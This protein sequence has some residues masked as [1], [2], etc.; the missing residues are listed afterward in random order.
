M[1]RLFNVYY[2][3]RTLVLL[4]VET[5]IVW[6]SF[7]LGRC[8]VPG[9]LLRRPELRGWI[10]KDPRCHSAGA[11]LFPLVRS[12]RSFAFKRKGELYFRLLLVP[13]LL[14]LSAGAVIGYFFPRFLLGQ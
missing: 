4:A 11:D 8:C 1:I 3:V 7:L 2:P 12:V 9:R 6:T 5:L 13:G 14:A 10:L